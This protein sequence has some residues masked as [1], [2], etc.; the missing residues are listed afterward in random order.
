MF[1]DNSNYKTMNK[2]QLVKQLRKQTSPFAVGDK[3]RTAS[4]LGVVKRRSNSGTC[5]NCT[6]I[7]GEVSRT[8]TVDRTAA[9]EAL[10]TS[11]DGDRTVGDDT[12][13]QDCLNCEE[14]RGSGH[15][16]DEM[17]DADGGN[18]VLDRTARIDPD[19]LHDGTSDSVNVRSKM[20]D[21]TAG[22]GSCLNSLM[23]AYGTSS[24]NDSDSA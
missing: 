14:D 11:P 19:T 17:H 20:H 9:S 6:A 8:D 4:D 23:S 12:G 16:K 5:G 2:H 22:R 1:T 7:C 10:F 13:K 21:G 3:T 15:G 18:K 24:S